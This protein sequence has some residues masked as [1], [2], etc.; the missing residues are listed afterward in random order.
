MFDHR[1]GSHGP[2]E[3]SLFCRPGDDGAGSGVEPF[4]DLGDLLQGFRFD[5]EK[6]TF[7]CLEPEKIGAVD[8]DSE[9]VGNQVIAA[10]PRPHLDEIAKFSQVLNSLLQQKFHDSALSVLN[11]WPGMPA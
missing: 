11:S 6:A 7:L 3:V 1:V 4:G 8:L 9:T 10:E 5:L 2:E